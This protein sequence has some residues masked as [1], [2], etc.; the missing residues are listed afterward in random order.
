MCGICGYIGTS[1]EPAVTYRLMTNLFAETQVRGEDASGLWGPI[2]DGEVLYHKEPIKSSIFVRRAFWGRVGESN[3]DL[4]VCHARAASMGVGVPSVNKNNHPFISGDG[5]IGLVHNGRIP[6]VEYK[7]LKKRYP[8]ISACDSEIVL[9]IFEA[10]RL[11]TPERV[12]DFAKYDPAVALGLAGMK[13]V[14][15]YLSLGHMAVAIGETQAEKIRRLWLFRNKH[16]SL[17]LADMRKQLG[18]VFFFSVPQIWREA[19]DK[20]EKADP[21]FKKFTTG[22]VKLIELP[23][24]EIWL[25]NTTTNIPVTDTQALRR[26]EVCASGTYTAW[27]EDKIPVIPEAIREQKVKIITNLLEDEKVLEE[28]EPPRRPIGYHTGATGN[29]NGNGNGLSGF[30]PSRTVSDSKTKGYP[31]APEDI[32]PN[33]IDSI[34]KNIQD[35]TASISTLF[36]NA[37]LAGNMTAADFTDLKAQLE[38]AEL[39]LTGTLNIMERTK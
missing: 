1:V 17:W 10:G 29:G 19:V 37:L 39:D 38:Q 23:P 16:R 18:Q 7:A 20:Y 14:W 3:P 24:D 8:V 31:L 6:D 13:D 9:R 28:P 4:L 32:D 5:T 36:S 33:A 34:T 12:K 30:V 15:S 11:A 22:G 25:F 21:N 2:N 35:I 27:A 26:F